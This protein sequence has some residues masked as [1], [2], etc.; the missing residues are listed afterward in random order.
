MHACCS[1]F[2][3]VIDLGMASSS[4]AKAKRFAVGSLMFVMTLTSGMHALRVRNNTERS[5]LIATRKTGLAHRYADRPC[6]TGAYL[7]CGS[8]IGCTDRHASDDRSNHCAD[9]TDLPSSDIVSVTICFPI[10]VR[11]YHVPREG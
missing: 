11:R 2:P 7:R 6:M 5:V 10:R 3:E 9:T 4:L 1:L 8:T